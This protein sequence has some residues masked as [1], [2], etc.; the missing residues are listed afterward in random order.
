MKK[1]YGNIRQTT[2]SEALKKNGFKD[3]WEINKDQIDV[4]KDCEFRY[5]CTDCRAFI[6]EPGNMF[7]KPLK[8]SYSPYTSL[9]GAEGELKD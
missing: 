7:S 1:S 3:Y 4:C 8:C 6:Q 9:W 2:L 5:I